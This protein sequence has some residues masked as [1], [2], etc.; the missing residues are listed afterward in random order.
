[1]NI[2][3]STHSFNTSVNYD[4]DADLIREL[5]VVK[6]EEFGF[7][8]SFNI[9]KKS[10]VS[11]GRHFDLPWWG[12]DERYRFETMILNSENNTDISVES[13]LCSYV[14]DDDN[15]L[16][17]DVLNTEKALY[18]EKGAVPV[19]IS[20]NIHKGNGSDTLRLRFN[21]YKSNAYDKEELIE[22]KDI[23]IN[24]MD[25]SLE[26]EDRVFYLDLWQHPCSWARTYGLEYYSER[27]F[28]L[29]EKYIK[30]L[31][32]LGESVTDL[33]VSDFPWA[34]QACFMIE[35]NPSRLYEYNM[36]RISK[37][38]GEFIYDFSIVDRY[39]E[40][41]MKYNICKEINLFGI[42]GNWHGF[43]FRSPMTDYE[44][45]IRVSFYDEDEKCY[46]YIRNK[47]DL[48]LYLKALFTHLDLKGYMDITKIIGDEPSDYKKFS[49]FHDF[50]S[51]C[52]DKK[53]EFKYALHSSTFLNEYKGSLESF[54]INS[55]YIGY[56]VKDGELEGILKEHSAKM[57]WYPCCF[58]K[59]FNTFVS[60]PLIES[61]YFGLYTYLWNFK[62]MLRWAYGLYTERP[63]ENISYKPEKWKAGDMFFVYP[64]K[65]M[66]IMH[67]IREK[68][69]LFAIQDFNIF[70]K[71]EKQGVDVEK[72][73]REKMEIKLLAKAGKEDI[74]LELDEYKDY[75]YY[76]KIR[77][78]L[79]RSVYEK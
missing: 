14:E 36:I 39:V 17:A 43:D 50:L 62:G 67:S 56:Y 51:S 21:L 19:Y 24:I 75:E 47:E 44:D 76:K 9:D 7:F 72:Y 54:S 73:L 1:M 61:R 41:C 27:H 68:N 15:T 45:P 40:L 59:K 70:K 57:T 55:A 23:S 30:G 48:R 78:E 20:S 53:L 79:I 8:V 58:P 42:C 32:V 38:N 37:R 63:L 2:Y 34:G 29:I 26:E 77:D 64:G 6:N 71:I 28:E 10:Y 5:S 65:D 11:L 74:S 12:L 13:Y 49:G 69:L 33:I 25:F 66:E 46:D 60:S 31:S 18:Y 22:S 3:S 52:Y 16:Y 35:K 4:P